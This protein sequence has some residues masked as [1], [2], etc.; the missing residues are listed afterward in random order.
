MLPEPGQTAPEDF[1]GVDIA[2]TAIPEVI[3]LTPKRFGDARGFFAETYSRR[4]LAE[5]GIDIDFVQDNLAY[6]RAAGTVRGLHFQ[7][8]AAQAKLVGVV[9]GAVLDVAL[10]IRGGS[11]TFGRHVA[12]TLTAAAGEQLLV[13]VGFAHG[14][15]TLEPDTRVAYK[16]SDVYAPEHERGI[17]W[18]DPA[19]AIRWPVA[20]ADAE[21]SERDRS[22][23]RLDQIESPFAY[24]AGRAQGAAR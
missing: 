24:A 12:V 11:P 4:A 13:P 23:P 2:A 5:A 18:H 17:L 1:D 15:C 14:Y 22:W 7:A 16:V 9:T 8:P 20:P 19:L 6:S 3:R 21:V 10:D